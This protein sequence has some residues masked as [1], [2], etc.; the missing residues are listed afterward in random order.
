MS[1]VPVSESRPKVVIT[2]MGVASPLGLTLPSLWDACRRGISGVRPFILR[3]AT[4]PPIAFAGQAVDFT[5]D[6]ADFG[7]PAASLKKDIRKS[8]KLMSREIQM[9][10][11]AAERA[12]QDAGIEQGALPPHRVGVS[13]A[14]DYIV[15]AP[16]EF[17]EGVAACLTD[18]QFDFSRWA[19][20]GKKK[21]TPIWQLKFLPNMPTSHISILN[22]FHGV[23]SAVMNRDA[24]IGTAVSEAVEII[25]SGKVDVMIVGAT[26]SLIHPYRLIPSILTEQLADASLAPEKASRPFDR[27]RTGLVLGEG[28]GSLVLESAEHALRR[29]A[30]IRAEVVGGACRCS[31]TRNQKPNDIEFFDTEN[32]ERLTESLLL[33]LEALFRKTGTD[34]ASVGHIAAHGAGNRVLDAAEATAIRRFFG[35]AADALPVTTL[36]GHMGNSGSG[37][38]ALDLIAS[39][40]ALENNALYPILNNETDD[41]DCPIHPVRSFGDNPGDSFVKLACQRYGHSSALLVRR[42][43][44]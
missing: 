30:A 15:T 21:M 25:K 29:G 35:D 38:G 20:D 27:D 42:Y 10:V 22:G 44:A 1:S 8:L 18:G 9:G 12:I 17:S 37:G 5:G 40:M 16:E 33:S 11:A 34:P 4:P 13:F 28:A 43:Q 41:P 6:I 36:K 39:V 19:T 2:G 14:S 7:T 32:R 23:G 31:I 26:G 3:G 24:S